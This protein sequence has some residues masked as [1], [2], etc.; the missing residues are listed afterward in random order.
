[1]SFRGL[2]WLFCCA[3]AIPAACGPD[4]K[5]PAPCPVQQDF[6]VVI[7][8]ESGDLPADT[9][10]VL[11]S[12]SGRE[13]YRL[14]ETNDLEVLFCEATDGG[15]GSTDTGGASGSGG[16][17]GASGAGG[18][19]AGRGVPALLCQ[20]WTQGPA[21]LEISAEGYVDHRE[22]LELEPGKCKVEAEIELVHG[23]GGA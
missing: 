4:P 7:K 9:V 22:E 5:P 20:L 6:D 10:V 19:R 3:L 21:T 18:A 12:G 23:D 8:A 15:G 11:I 17:G 16:F 14:G 13:E 2:L 1:L